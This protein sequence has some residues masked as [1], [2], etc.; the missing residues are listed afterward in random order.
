MKYLF[1]LKKKEYEEGANLAENNAI[2][3]LDASFVLSENKLYSFAV[4]HCILCVEEL[5]KASVLK[6]KAIDNKINIPDFDKYFHSHNT[7][8]Q[9]I[10]KL[11][12][13]TINLNKSNEEIKKHNEIFMWIIIAVAGIILYKK[14]VSKDEKE[15]IDDPLAH[16]NSIESLR[17][18]SI[19]VELLENRNWHSPQIS[20][21]Q[22]FCKEIQEF[23]VQ[24][25]NELSVT[26]F[27][28][29][30]DRTNINRFLE[31]LHK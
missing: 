19:Y 21:S 14:V 11:L 10:F 4:T 13:A 30:V 12:G 8:H 26:L 7:K 28:K 9:S 17:L 15:G 27:D 24:I 1:K 25:F 18:S 23:T 3:H 5:T 31:Q 2:A 20:F 6:L 22:E 16:I 29:K